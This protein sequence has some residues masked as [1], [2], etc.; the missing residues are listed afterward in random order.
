M[1]DNLTWMLKSTAAAMD[2]VLE[3]KNPRDQCSPRKTEKSQDTL[4]RPY[5]TTFQSCFSNQLFKTLQVFIVCLQGPSGTPCKYQFHLGGKKAAHCA[6]MH[7][8]GEPAGRGGPGVE[9]GSLSP[10]SGLLL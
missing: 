10:G 9:C 6:E 1:L 4:K 7:A 3:C 5:Y 2:I 8:E